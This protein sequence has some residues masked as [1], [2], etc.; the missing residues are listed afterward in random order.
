MG[1]IRKVATER[2]TVTLSPFVRDFVKQTVV[3]PLHHLPAH[4]N[5]FP[6]H[7]P[8]P[9]GDLYHWIPVLD[10]F[11]H[12]IEIF[13]KEYS[14][15]EGPQTQPFAQR[16]LERGDYEEGCDYP[17]GGA[18]AQE[19][20]S[21][22]WSAEGD[23]ELIEPIIH[24]SRILL[25]HCGNRSL[26][27]SSAHINDLL[28][29]TSPG[30]L[31]LCL[32]LSLRLAQRYQVA[33]YKNAHPPAQASL[34]ANHYNFNFDNLHKIALPFPKPAGVIPSFAQSAGKGKDKAVT[35]IAFNGADLVSLVKTPLS[36]SLKVEMS[37]VSL[38]YY[39]QA[40]VSQRQNQ[41][42]QPPEA[43]PASPTPVRRTSNLGPSRD[44]PPVGDR[45]MSAID[46][47]SSPSKAREN[48]SIASSPLSY[49]QIPAAKI[50]GSQ[51]WSIMRDALPT[52]PAECRYDLLHRVRVAKAFAS[53][54]DDV[55][56]LV[57]IRLLAIA[58]LAYALA[59]SKFQEKI[60]TP[61]SEEPRP[62][63]LAQQLCDLLQPA[64]SGQGEV[65]PDFE[66]TVLIAIEAL[67]KA[68][69]KVSEVADALAITVNHGIL[70]F[71]L[72]RVISTLKLA[73]KPEKQAEL[74]AMEW[75]D[76]T[77]DLINSL[78]QTGAQW[79]YGE[80]MVS[81][82]IIGILVEALELRTDR[83]DR[84]HEKVLQFFDS[85]IHG[86]PSALQ[87][88]A[89]VRGLDIVADLTSYVVQKSLADVRAGNGLPEEFKSKVIDYTIPYY[90]QSALRQLFKNTAHMFD[91][92]TG[93][94]D[95]LLRN[96]IDTPQ[97]LDALRSVIENAN[98][99]GSNVWSGAVNI[100]NQ[101][102]NHEPTMYQ[103]IG[104]AGLTKSFLDSITGQTSS[105]DHHQSS[106][107]HQ[108][109][110]LP[111]GEVMCDIP[112]V[113][114][115]ICLNESGM[116]AFQ[117]SDAL[118][119]YFDIF[120]SPV[121][122]R[123]MEEEGP[124]AGTIGHSFDELSRHQP[125]LKSQITLA[126][127]KM[128]QRLKTRFA[129]FAQGARA[130]AKLLERI[131]GSFESLG[132]ED[133]PEDLSRDDDSLSASL[134]PA[135]RSSTQN[136]I[137]VELGR[138][139]APAMH[140]L[141]A[142]FKFLDGLFANQHMCAAFCEIGGVESLLDLAL[143]PCHPHDLGSFPVFGKVAAVLKTMC[144]A[145]SHLVLPSLL[146]RT[147]H[148]VSSLQ[149]FATAQ[150]HGD[151]FAKYV[152]LQPPQPNQ[153]DELD[154]STIT[155]A[156]LNVQM[157]THILG[158]TLS[159][160]YTIRHGNQS[161]Q[162]FTSLN[163]TDV[164]IRLAEDL[165]KLQ[166]ACI[167]E[168]IVTYH[169]LPD[170]VKRQTDPRRYS[171]RRLNAD[172]TLEPL[173]AD[174]QLLAAEPTADNE[175]AK[176]TS[177][178]TMLVLRNT[179][180]I[181]HLLEHVPK[182]IS[183]FIQSLG[184]AIV[185]TRRTDPLVRQH[186]SHIAERVAKSII[187]SFDYRRCDASIE[188]ELV[189]K[190]IARLLKLMGDL[191]LRKSLEAM[192]VDDA[193]TLVLNKFF[194]A[195]GFD[196]LN[197][198][199]ASFVEAQSREPDLVVPSGSEAEF[200]PAKWRAQGMHSIL[201]FYDQ[202]VNNKCIL[203]AAQSTH[204][205]VKERAS[206]DFFI[207]AQFTVEIRDCVLPAVAQIWTS[208]HLE[209]FSQSD[210][211]DVVHILRLILEG[212][213][214]ER[215]LRRSERAFR[216]GAAAPLPQKSASAGDVA[217]L[218]ELGYDG[219][220]AREALYRC[221]F[222]FSHAEQYCKLRQSF[223]TP[224]FPPPQHDR[225]GDDQV[226]TDESRSSNEGQAMDI[227]VVQ[228]PE[229]RT[230]A[231]ARGDN[232][233]S[234]SE[235][236][237]NEDEDDD[238]EEDNDEEEEA[239]NNEDN[240]GESDGNDDNRDDD[241]GSLG[242]LPQHLR[243]EDF[244]AMI[245]T[246]ALDIALGRSEKPDDVKQMFVTVDDLDEKRTKLRVNLIE[247]CLEV[248]SAHPTITFELSDLIQAAMSKV[249]KSN[250]TTDVGE[251]LVTSLISLHTEELNKDSGAKIHAHAHLVAL[252]LQDRNFFDS[253][254][255]P[256][257]R[258]FGSL[259][260]WL[261]L[262]PEQKT[263]EAPWIE[264]IL[265]IIER[266]LAEDEQPVEVTWNPTSADELSN[267]APS[268]STPEPLV[269]GAHRSELFSAV[270][271][272]LPRIGKNASFALSVCRI[273]VILTRRRE[274]A[275]RFSER[276]H[277]GRLF[278]MVRQLA[279]ALGEAVP[280]CIMMILRHMI[281]DDETVRQI[282]R[283]E[284]RAVFQHPARPLR[285]VDT[286]SYTRSVYHLV[287]RNP[288]LFVE[289]SQELLMITNLLPGKPLDTAQ[290]LSLKPQSSS[291]EL[292]TKDSSNA[293][294]AAESNTTKPAADIK[295]PVSEASD[296][297]TQ[298]LLRELS[299][300]K[301]VDDKFPAFLAQSTKT[302]SSTKTAEARSADIEMSDASPSNAGPVPAQN[303]AATPVPAKQEGSTIFLYRRFILQC[304]T[305]ILGSYSRTKVEFIN[306]SRKS[307]SQASTPSRPRAG[308]L[309]YL[310]N[311]LL[312]VGTLEHKDDEAH[313]KRVSIS[314]WASLVLVSLCLKVPG[315]GD[316]F[317]PT[318]VVSEGESELVFVRKFVLEHA[319]RSFK[320]A[321]S[322][323]EPLDMR[324]SRLLCLGDL[325]DKVLNCRDELHRSSTDT[326][327]N[328]Q[329]IGRL[330]YEKG[331]ISTLTAAIAE[332]D[333]NFPNAKRT[334]KYILAPLKQLTSLGV[335]LSQTTDATVKHP[336][337]G[338]ND[339]EEE[340][341]VSSDTSLS[342]DDDD[343]DREQTP[344]LFR[345]SSLGMFEASAGQDDDSDDESGEEEDDEMYDEHELYDD[346]YDEHEMDYED[347]VVAEHGDVVSD[348]DD[349]MGPMEGVPGDMALDV[350]MIMEDDEDSMDDDDDDD[351]D[352]DDD[353]DDEDLLEEV[354][355]D[356]GHDEIIGDEGDGS[357]ADGDDAEDW[358]D[359][360]IHYG[361]DRIIIEDGDGSALDHI[362][363]VIGA[364]DDPSDD[365]HEH[366][367]P[368][369]LIGRDEDFF[370]DELEP[371][372]GEEEI[373]DDDGELETDIIYEP[374]VDDDE[375]GEEDG[376]WD[377][378]WD[379]PAPQFLFRGA[380]H[381]HPQHHGN[382]HHSRGGGGI[383]SM[384]MMDLGGGPLRAG[385]YRSHRSAPNVHDEEGLNPL[386]QRDASRHRRDLTDL[387]YGIGRL[388]QRRS[389]LPGP[390]DSPL[391]ELLNAVGN[392]GGTGVINVNV[393]PEA[394]PALAGFPAMLLQPG[395]NGGPAAIEIDP[396]RLLRHGTSTWPSHF[397]SSTAEM[398]T[399]GQYG[400]GLGGSFRIGT[401]VGRWQEVART[402]FAN[403]AIEKAMKIIKRLLQVLVPPAEAA[404]KQKEKEDLE[405]KAAEEERR[406]KVEA[407]RAE[408]EAQE[409]RAREEEQA[410]RKQ[411][412][413]EQ[414]ALA[415]ATG[416]LENDAETDATHAEQRQEQEAEG[417]GNDTSSQR[418]TITIRGRELDIT[419]LGIDPEYLE[420]LPEDMRE[421]VIASQVQ[422]QQAQARSQAVRTN[423]HPLEISQ[424]FLDAL[425]PEIQQEL[426]RSEEIQRRQRQREEEARNRTAQTGNPVPQD[427]NNADFMAMLDPNLRQ[428]VLMDADESILA[429]L[430][431][432]LQ[433]EARLLTGNRGV[434]GLGG[435]GA[436]RDYEADLAR[437]R[438]ARTAAGQ[439]ASGTGAARGRRPAAAMLDKSGIATLLRLMFVS[440]NHKVRTNLHNV[441]SDICKNT[442][443]RAEVISIL[444]SILQDGTADVN[445]MERSF[446]NLSLR[447]KQASGPK[448]PQPLKRS[449][450]GQLPP[451]LTT[452]LSPLNIVQQCLGTLNALANDNL[453]VPSF[454][455]NEHETS[456]TQKNKTPSKK[457][458]ARETRAMKFPLNALLT[459]LDRKLITENTAVMEVLA[460][461]LSHVTHP[462]N[463]LLRRARDAQLQETAEV[464]RSSGIEQ[465]T[466]S[467]GG[468]T[469]MSDN[470]GTEPAQEL[471]TSD[472]PS[473][474]EKKPSP[475]DTK[476]KHRDLSPPEVPEENIRLVVN[477]LAARECPSR[478]FSDTLD[479]IKNLSAIP[480]AKA[481]FGKELI[482]QAQ[483]LGD[484]LVADL[485]ELAEQINSASAD[486]NLQGIAL[487]NFSSAGSKQ[488]RML[489]VLVALDHLFDP[490]RLVAST[491]ATNPDVA[492]DQK[493]KDD[494]LAT[495]YQT[496][497]FQ[498]L[499]KSLSRCLAEIRNRGNMVNVATILLPLIESLMVVCRN[500]ALRD[501][502]TSGAS[503]I[504]SASERMDRLFL[505]F[506]EDN[507][508]ILNELIRNNPKLMKGNLSVL[509]KNS[510]VLEF[511]NK[512][513]YFKSKLHDRRSES[514]ASQPSL[515]LSV[516]REHVFADSFK[517]LYFRTGDEIKYGKLNIRFRGEEGIDAGGVSREWFTA[518]A[519]QMFLADYALFNS[520]ASDRTT[521]HPNAL[522]EINDEHLVTFKFVGR[523]IGKALYE[524]RHL[525][526]HFSRAVY[527]RIL[528][529]S[530]SLKDMES[531]DLDYYKSLVWI[532]ENDITDVTFE[533][534][535]YDMERFG[536]TE[537]VDLIENGRNVPVTQENKQ[538]Y[539][540]LVVEYR[541]L[542][543]VQDQLDKFLE[544]FYEIVPADLISIFNEQELEL[545]ISGLPEIDVDDWKSNTEYHNYQS[546]SPQIQWFWRAVRSFDQEERAKLLQ[547]VT[548]T[549]RV[550]LAGFKEL[551]GMNGFARFNIHRD[552]SSK[553][554]LPSS[555]T[556]FNR[557]CL[558]SAHYA[559][560]PQLTNSQNSISR[561]TRA[562]SIFDINFTLRLPPAAS[563]LALHEGLLIVSCTNKLGAYGALRWRWRIFER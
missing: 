493:L 368:T 419:G 139:C 30:L 429:V 487:A 455:L 167:W 412:A 472:D 369:N 209:R 189:P 339:N 335:T 170:S 218:E 215:A 511:D 438:D 84:F 308:M 152:H 241:P 468:D 323:I 184:V 110:I 197:E 242:N 345:G 465:S 543:S 470:T 499:W 449:F 463:I 67:T 346:G 181:R 347:E 121:H 52:V 402:L 377:G 451:S 111:V 92:H 38:S 72:R 378:R 134:V 50:S 103:V 413:A 44:R 407:E 450:T 518:M 461:L 284:I 534:F 563:T 238:D 353:D 255:E 326:H 474:T 560:P 182:G 81:A 249:D 23:R 322:S 105:G 296:G 96:L 285:T 75:R 478:T 366:V 321:T 548:G 363:H 15:N 351:E 3:T 147:Q 112:S 166:A 503:P 187:W 521:F 386:L 102:I 340:G 97:T 173:I 535:S 392:P 307:E 128:L 364:D 36:S 236:S 124:I 406:R 327:V 33:R 213:G 261:Q 21:N 310:L 243:Q 185:P 117:D 439:S 562:T 82:G 555:H 76:A 311:V 526:A 395:A 162:L 390:R 234:D 200:T 381:H 318:P 545:L 471:A 14:L 176:N 398:Q 372:E 101:F 129:I 93:T 259:I 427:I 137:G 338:A 428:S 546:T 27:A 231:S 416:S 494:I 80:R 40:S 557:K 186:A 68:R 484:T 497:T 498:A 62:Y 265:L 362:A 456:G 120:L 83:A 204:I 305:E 207:P 252:V 361:R 516:R 267:V 517:D 500:S 410:R 1:R 561:N 212:G 400:E 452:E 473:T 434:Q 360:D 143:S 342:D 401:T 149:A 178:R 330:M 77:F 266:V 426:I 544:G 319:L 441:L 7:W 556:C 22:G 432:A 65:P 160:G 344:D 547:F 422:S 275:L 244:S 433:A 277:I 214:E 505:T 28:H 430:P 66:T 4:L 90:K 482:R 5:S 288:E 115:A 469:H 281:E 59:D 253:A 168:D 180:T 114:G 163:F 131:D 246:G 250:A 130:G 528:G 384:G 524:G 460:S 199:L 280:G 260:S 195:G 226:V 325:F 26:Y 41:A 206:A 358:E 45:S 352:D 332:L 537:T 10:R 376:R 31:H 46:L 13:N 448:T 169:G 365:F 116:Q 291:P 385:G 233:T 519:R 263:E 435:R 554:K 300:Y 248:L 409:K 523:I 153:P 375:D 480:G 423:D 350:E 78:M 135:R 373:I 349:D 541:L 374:D 240:D 219:T 466:T 337:N 536:V 333:L 270:L 387:P 530:V 202:I 133:A 237:D 531:L 208:S 314:H 183:L 136:S 420:A 496:T 123:A 302:M 191:F 457:S 198:Y 60:G 476:K 223:P 509:A 408:K 331:F 150:N 453:R 282:M 232:A 357:L 479:L 224:R 25:E 2:H 63:H 306:F 61:D 475:A 211:K 122:L 192:N 220:L 39:D 193:L 437:I 273:L 262:Q 324:Y 217:K 403:K 304:L 329:E 506:T 294:T 95:R 254:L 443:N 118:T 486:A 47:G 9:R 382:H 269:S 271:D 533:T 317:S 303:D 446:A 272:L 257:K 205:A 16:V 165:I 179:R 549:S 239:R 553:E 425:P 99:F 146:Q 467:G 424:E 551:E 138:D 279:G 477:I 383:F 132:D 394:L 194:I 297:V 196:K 328:R 290:S 42:M 172:G 53:Q 51:A 235:M 177:P 85:F 481:I 483:D 397:P 507:R 18:D 11:D 501:R 559:E 158:R 140:Y 508:K 411:E 12:I 106:D 148:A 145:R 389:L 458:K 17:R 251:T 440:L 64:Q 320:E 558:T 142:V 396:R 447:A 29:T 98:I 283:T 462:L 459:L 58:N 87:T 289:V 417:S 292:D 159:P 34:L 356:E 216:H 203:D 502:K 190:Y 230:L 336:G 371:E 94:Q 256:L 299:N 43:T 431:E 301:D 107:H 141:S 74:V 164:Y 127:D 104:E 464:E 37:Y 108:I 56:Q 247:R 55:V 444:L 359:D 19:L 276:Q 399:A 210:M 312:P 20:E 512:Q 298:F 538:E 161:T 119:R 492:E 287:I 89:N 550:P 229:A 69:H 532:L 274:L 515:T 525:D 157:L 415:A 313:H 24:F 393:D 57:E 490:K 8:L 258:C 79:R 144:D 201:A 35:N 49:C 264:M 388:A 91:H 225:Q 156:L 155:K 504:G 227:E 113:F 174:E 295:T 125:R 175:N 315:T 334:V 32:K 355:F 418:I 436:L 228:N 88:L 154:G 48:D 221:N 286:T 539:V 343:E 489:R 70:Y 442:Q 527:R 485:N 316:P 495:F 510:K 454:F 348:E 278:L 293:G 552:Y 171:P 109:G 380:A 71:V 445:A 73:E 341:E 520:V 529:K 188:Q 542:K 414:E 222:Y 151:T 309:N 54:H 540:R 421:D 391:Q 367:I 513:N 514:R 354:E 370:E 100:V 491:N 6:Q 405:R 268:L 522:S 488:R 404:R 126:I 86:I 245:S 379:A